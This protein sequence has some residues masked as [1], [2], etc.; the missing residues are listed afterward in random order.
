VTPV[1]LAAMV[2][3]D[4]FMARPAW[5]TSTQPTD[6]RPV[7]AVATFWQEARGNPQA[8]GKPV[9]LEGHG[10]AVAL[11]LCQLL[12]A[13]HVDRGPYA[14]VPRMTVAECMDPELNWR[15]A[16][17]IMNRGRTGWLYN[18]SPWSAFTSGAYKPH[19]PLA[20]DAVRSLGGPNV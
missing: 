10:W 3:G 17:L 5:P 14:D 4:G 12:S 18:L 6:W 2:C 16:W 7:T 20:L 1:E 8:V 9:L 13:Y 19:L 15:R 11:G